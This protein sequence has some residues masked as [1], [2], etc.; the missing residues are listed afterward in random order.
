MGEWSYLLRD[1]RASYRRVLN[2]NASQVGPT[3]VIKTSPALRGVHVAS[4]HVPIPK[5]PRTKLSIAVT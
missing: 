4:T 5:P 1:R 2:W 3:N